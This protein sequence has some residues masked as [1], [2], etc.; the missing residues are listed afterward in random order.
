MGWKKSSNDLSTAEDKYLEACKTYGEDSPEARAAD[1]A[2][3]A[4]ADSHF[5]TYGNPNN[6]YR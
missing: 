4:E 5:G 3:F 1:E 6:R 2:A